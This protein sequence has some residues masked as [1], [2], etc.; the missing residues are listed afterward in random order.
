MKE[1]WNFLKYLDRIMPYSPKLKWNEMKK[2][3]SDHTIW[4]GKLRDC[5]HQSRCLVVKNEQWT[6][7]DVM[8]KLAKN[9]DGDRS[10]KWRERWSECCDK[11]RRTR[12]WGRGLEV[13][14]APR[15]HLTIG[16]FS[17]L[18]GNKRTQHTQPPG[19][20]TTDHYSHDLE[21]FSINFICGSS[22]L[23]FWHDA[24]GDPQV[25]ES[26]EKI[27]TLRFIRRH[28]TKVSWEGGFG[29]KNCLRF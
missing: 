11:P 25:I 3:P 5:F 29:Y 15:G 10:E 24:I 8:G 20:G 23:S 16:D 17:S 19:S 7:L 28:K 1:G 22:F 26:A 18:G 21:N 12:V 14:P 2:A 6:A 9:L 13:D 4:K 27:K